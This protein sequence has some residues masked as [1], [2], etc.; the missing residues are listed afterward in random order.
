LNVGANFSYVNDKNIYGALGGSAANQA[1]LDITGGLPNVVFRQTRLNLFGEYAMQKSAS[2]RVDLV[3]FHAKL[4]EWTWGYN[5][6]PFVYSDGATVSINPNQHVTFIG[7]S[8]IY[9]WQ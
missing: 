1:T 8:Y 5:G 2:V 6:V 9:R 7:A 4:N 3:D